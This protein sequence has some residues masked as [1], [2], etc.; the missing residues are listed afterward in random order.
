MSTA[1][2]STAGDHSLPEFAAALFRAQD[3]DRPEVVRELF[4]ADATVIDVDETFVGLQEIQRWLART[5]TEFSYTRQVVSVIHPAPGQWRLVVHL[6]G[7]F[8]G[9]EV[10]LVFDAETVDGRI[11]RLEIQPATSV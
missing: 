9:G 2:A 6:D 1:E 11:R 8:P 7:D 4:T 3:D 10:D 5:N